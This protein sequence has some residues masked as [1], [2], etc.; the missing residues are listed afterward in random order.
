[1]EVTHQFIVH[2][3]RSARSAPIDGDFVGADLLPSVMAT[4]TK[5]VVQNPPVIR[6]KM[7]IVVCSCGIFSGC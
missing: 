1:M 2:A 5:A 3:A 4:A 7:T 6:D